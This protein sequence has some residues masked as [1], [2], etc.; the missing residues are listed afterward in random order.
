MKPLSIMLIAGDPSGD[1][2]AAELV[3]ALTRAIT[4]AEFQITSDVQ[5]LTT[6]LRPRFFG[7]GGPKMAQAGVELAFDL[8]ADS[9]IGLSDVI[10]KLPLFR[11][12]FRQH[13]V[14]LAIER[15]PDLI[16]LVDYDAFNR[17]WAHAIKNYVRRH[18]GV[19]NNWR[20]KIVRYVSPQ[21]WASRPGRAAK[22]ARDIDLL[23]CL[24]PFEKEWYAKRLPALR[25]EF[26]GHPMFDRFAGKQPAE[27][28]SSN[29]VVL[30]PA[31]T[32]RG[33]GCGICR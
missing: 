9:V 1:A 27:P 25:V 26:V 23:L 30:L 8:T 6:P 31:A 20:P 17:R 29:T 3:H 10:K 14:D 18:E 11:R 5:P 2:N 13:L 22:M 16:I 28:N 12:R 4:D 24:F 21:V 19:F 32:A 15:E 7:A 33:I